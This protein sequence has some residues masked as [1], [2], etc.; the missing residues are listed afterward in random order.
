MVTDVR[1]NY[2]GTQV[3]IAAYA[4]DDKGLCVLVPWAETRK[5]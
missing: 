1:D 2:R 3:H 5:S 4:G